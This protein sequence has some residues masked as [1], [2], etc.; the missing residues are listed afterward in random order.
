METGKFTI[1]Y[2]N[3]FREAL[4]SVQSDKNGTPIDYNA[5][6][7]K[8]VELLSQVQR[9]HK[10]V[11]MIGNG[12]SAGIASHMAV[13][14]WKNGKIRATAFNDPALLTCIANDYSYEEVFAKP[15]EAF[16]DKGDVVICISS[17][18]NSKNIINAA[19]QAVK[20]GCIVLTFSGFA[21][22]NPLRKLGNLNFYAPSS[23]YGFVELIHNLIIHNILD[24]K[25]YCT[26]KLDVFNK[27]LPMNE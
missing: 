22:E 8:A 12:G 20:S 25:L 13:D 11:M 5:S 19:R 9:Q 24:A 2:L 10:K 6:I 26:D 16:A 15:I 7:H 21:P 1:K 4:D 3:S 17:S 23:S 18:G 27:N 14:Y